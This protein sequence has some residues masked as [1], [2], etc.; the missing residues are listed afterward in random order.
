MKKRFRLLSMLLCIG[1][2]FSSDATYVLASGVS[3]NS[4]VIETTPAIET[5][6]MDD[7]E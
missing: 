7:S 4:V 2:L 6:E 3:G 5:E 1:I